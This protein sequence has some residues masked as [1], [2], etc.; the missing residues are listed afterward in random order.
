MKITTKKKKK[1]KNRKKK[2]IILRRN[3]TKNCAEHVPKHQMKSLLADV[4]QPYDTHSEAYKSQL[5]CY[6][7]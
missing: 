5:S 1:K 3:D 2:N 4:K 7:V 6:V